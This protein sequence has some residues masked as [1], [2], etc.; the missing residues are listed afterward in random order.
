[1]IYETT[2]GVLISRPYAPTPVYPPSPGVRFISHSGC[3]VVCNSPRP[4]GIQAFRA[5]PR[6]TLLMLRLNERELRFGESRLSTIH[7]R[8]TRSF[9]LLFISL[10]ML[11]IIDHE[12]AHC[13]AARANARVGSWRSCPCFLCASALYVERIS[14][15]QQCYERKED[16][17]DGVVV[18]FGASLTEPPRIE[19]RLE[20][21]R[22]NY[23]LRV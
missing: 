21:S 23:F 13:E 3:S 14:D 16:S 22:V 6:Y 17:D 5:P 2:A 1:V 11:K 9:F 8:R 15:G 4:S 12:F 20:S 19:D 7:R 10:R 18:I